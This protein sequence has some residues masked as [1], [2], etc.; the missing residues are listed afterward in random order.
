MTFNSTRRLFEEFHPKRVTQFLR[1][2]EMVSFFRFNKGNR[3]LSPLGCE[4]IKLS[5]KEGNARLKV[6]PNLP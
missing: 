6:T 3:P 4:Q 2:C 5:F 1:H